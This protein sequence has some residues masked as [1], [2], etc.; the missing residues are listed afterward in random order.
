LKKVDRLPDMMRYVKT[1]SLLEISITINK[2]AVDEHN[3]GTVL[4]EFQG[5]A[6]A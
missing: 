4:P 6:C 3:A 5:E 2:F 1:R